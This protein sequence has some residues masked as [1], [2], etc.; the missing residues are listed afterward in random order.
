MDTTHYSSCI[1]TETNRTDTGGKHQLVKRH[2]KALLID[3][4]VR[5]LK[6]YSTLLCLYLCMYAICRYINFLLLNFQFSVLCEH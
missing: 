1:A 4:A 5:G 3:V 6:R 2:D